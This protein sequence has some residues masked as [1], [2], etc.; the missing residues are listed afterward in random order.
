M[1][2]KLYEIK[3]LIVGPLLTNCYLLFSKK[4]AAV[5]DPGGG[6]KTILKEIEESGA[7]LKFII[8]THGHWDHT[9]SIL[10]IKEKTGARILLHEAEKE[11]V[12]FKTDQFLKDGEEI[13]IGN[14]V[15]KVIHTPGHTKGSICL[16]GNS[17][18]F[19]G[20][21]IFKDGYG[22]TDLVGGSQK[23]LENSL[24]KLSKILKPGMKIYPGHGD[25][26]KK[27]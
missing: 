16:L 10:K 24:K 7:K 19:T 1:V 23:D 13:K 17:F 11:F 21:T 20:D 3:H 14:I 15:L 8:L 6:T 18:I 4:E 12:K 25:I 27:K 5:I 9:L 26:F 22:R 2:S